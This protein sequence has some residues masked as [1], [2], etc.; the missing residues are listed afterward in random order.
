[1]LFSTNNKNHMAN[2]VCDVVLEKDCTGCSACMN[3]CPFAAITM[4][5]N[6]VG[7][8]LPAIDG[9]KCVECG[10]CTKVCP[11]NKTEGLFNPV[12]K[13]Y[14]SWAKDVNEHKS[15]SSGGLAS[16]L[17]KYIVE[18]GG[19]VY[20]CASL[21]GCVIQHIR[22]DRKSDV[23]LLKG[24]K[25]VQ[26]GIGFS[27]KNI[28]KDLAEGKKVLFI[29][30]PCQVAGLRS[31][32]Q[33]EY[34]GLF[35][36]DL[37]CHGV[38]SQRLLVDHV[39]SLAFD[40]DD[41]NRIGFRENSEYIISFRDSNNVILYRKDDMHDLFF[42]GYND[43]LFFR[44]SCVTC[45]YAKFARTG[46]ITLGDFHGLGKYASFNEITNGAVSLVLVNTEKGEILLKAIDKD[47]ELRERSLEEAL[48]SNPNFS[49]PSK[50][51]SDYDKFVNLYPK[52][53]YKKAAVR[54]MRLRLIKNCILTIRYKIN[55]YL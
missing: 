27:Y 38:P 47:V 8:I 44:E 33:K 1:M 32:L 14:A 18:K 26:S 51:K 42:S 39:S 36:I 23:P 19:I 21:K 20:G 54:C 34:E 11:A 48:Q 17:S 52:I 6:V 53:G 2:T 5:G 50:R 13:A 45:K 25:Y 4:S 40:T 10:F 9:N 49:K 55:K 28:K 12:K 35:T 41:I 37:V 31:Y 7:H 22:V 24:S 30:T 46:D 3:V 15:S 43:G 16:V 29:G